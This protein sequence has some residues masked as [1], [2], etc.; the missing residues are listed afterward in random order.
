LTITYGLAVLASVF[1]VPYRK[2]VLAGLGI[3]GILEVIVFAGQSDAWELL[4]I[5]FP[6]SGLLLAAAWRMRAGA[7]QPA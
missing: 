3:I 4:A 2:L 6:A 5:V 1:L 7:T